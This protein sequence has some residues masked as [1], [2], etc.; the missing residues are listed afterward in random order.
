VNLG[1][2]RTYIVY[3]VGI[4]R[5]VSQADGGKT[6]QNKIGVFKMLWFKIKF[7]S[8][9]GHSLMAFNNEAE[10]RFFFRNNVEIPVITQMEIF[11]SED[12]LKRE[13]VI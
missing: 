7:H 5:L 11:K 6:V 3:K 10:A 13:G 8:S 2:A 1:I 4:R 12:R 9:T